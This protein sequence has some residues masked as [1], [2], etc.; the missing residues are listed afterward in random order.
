[1]NALTATRK[2]GLR[3]CDPG[4]REHRAIFMTCEE[5]E[6]LANYLAAGHVTCFELV[7][8]IDGEWKETD[9]SA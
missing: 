4:H 8:L 3:C 1:M 9:V 2:F 7:E 5:R 6:P